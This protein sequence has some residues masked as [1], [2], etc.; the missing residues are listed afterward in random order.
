MRETVPVNADAGVGGAGRVK[1]VELPGGGQ[2]AKAESDDLKDVPGG[3]EGRRVA[4]GQSEE[5]ARD[6]KKM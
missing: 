5:K 6:T 1:L 3:H 4:R 2:G